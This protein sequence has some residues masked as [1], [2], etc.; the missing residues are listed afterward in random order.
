MTGVQTCALPI[1]HRSKPIGSCASSCRSS[2]STESD[3][4]ARI[5]RLR[6]RLP[7]PRPSLRRPRSRRIRPPRHRR[8]L[9][10]RDGELPLRSG[11][12]PLP[13]FPPSSPPCTVAGDHRVG[14]ASHGLDW[15]RARGRPGLAPAWAGPKAGWLGRVPGLAPSL[16]WPQ[17]GQGLARSGHPPACIPAWP[18][19]RPACQGF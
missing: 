3:R 8:A 18:V 11:N 15:P 19:W 6:P 9:P 12:L 14:H 16:G 13:R 1:S 5:R 10:R 7:P 2:S 17:A 4:G